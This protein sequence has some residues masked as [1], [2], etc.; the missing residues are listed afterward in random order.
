MTA[1]A[2]QVLNV[3]GGPCGLMVANELGRR[4][5]VTQLVDQ[6]AEVATAPQ[7]NATQARSMEHYRRLGFAEEIRGLG[8]Q[9]PVFLQPGDVVRCKITGIGAIENRVAA[10]R[11]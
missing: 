11:R 9:P 6:E 3:G 4:G 5:I 8:L 10:P 2:T 7:V 1:E